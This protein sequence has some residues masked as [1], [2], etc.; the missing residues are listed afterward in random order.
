MIKFLKKNFSDYIFLLKK[1]S[2]RWAIFFS[3]VILAIAIVAN[4]YAGSYVIKS[5][6]N[7]VTDLILS[8]IRVYDV[9][10]IFVNGAI[11]FWLIAGLIVLSQPLKVPFSIKSIALFILI[12]SVF[13]SLTHIAPYPISAPIASSSAFADFIIGGKDLFFS[14]H[15]G[16]PF[17]L[18]LI[19]WDQKYLRY[20]FIFS[21]FLFG[22]VTLLGH[23]H[24]SIDV[25]AAF[26]IS[27][28]IFDLAIFLFRQDYRIFKGSYYANSGN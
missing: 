4:N 9:D 20:L 27:Y 16:L 17:L 11:I 8:N 28:A 13:V 5:A 23:Y 7:P 24:Y 10:G 1:K 12:R 26:F 22:T 3:L 19:F 21:S 18:A 25:L 6:S 2:Y 14:A 15:T